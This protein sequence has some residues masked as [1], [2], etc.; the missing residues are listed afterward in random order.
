MRSLALAVACLL[1]AAAPAGAQD[2]Q[3]GAAPSVMLVFDASKSMND[4]A[5]GGQTRL[6]AAQD[7]LVSLIDT[8]PD[9]A[10]LGLR[11]FG[12]ELSD[13]SRARGCRDT[14]LVFPVGT[15]SRGE[16]KRAIRGFDARGRTP[17][18]FALR[19]AGDDL[20]EEGRRTIVLVSDGGS[21]C[22]PPPPC[23]VAREVADRGVDLSI[24]AIGFQV[25][26]RARSELQC[27]AEAGG[28]S[29]AD[30]ADARQLEGE[31]RR[32]SLGALRSF[33]ASGRAIRGGPDFR[34]A[35]R[36]APGQY[37]DALGP[38]EV[39]WYAV[40]LQRGQ[41]LRANAT[42]ILKGFERVSGEL[43]IALYTPELKSEF[44]NKDDQFLRDDTESV[45][46]E[47]GPV[48]AP[49]EQ[50]LAQAG[51]YLVRV[52][53]EDP[54]GDLPPRDVPVELVFDVSGTPQAAPE[55]EQS[56]APA[57]QDDEP[58]VDPAPAAAAGEG[59]NRPLLIAGVAACLALGAAAGFLGVAR[60]GGRS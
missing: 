18:A 2:D 47:I 49:D 40:P 60:R 14:K 44:D 13:V 35:T 11:V 52:S 51:A 41:T 29:Y 55:P 50:D 46:T 5:G 25:S 57:R 24:Q 42:A 3:E 27:I 8:I 1:V 16:L 39:R 48:G 7:A 38:G 19:A 4:E 53:L 17:I 32:L 30:A 58:L 43:G 56:P 33:A 36:V 12:S 45:G 34:R 23:D 37:T 31:L 6:E 26:P 28:G 22:A 10:R 9:E 20:P 21:N 15:A 59:P 54:S